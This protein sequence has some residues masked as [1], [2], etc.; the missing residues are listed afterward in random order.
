MKGRYFRLEKQKKRTITTTEIRIF[1]DKKTFALPLLF[2]CSSA[3]PPLFL[4]T[5]LGEAL[6][7]NGIFTDFAPTLHRLWYGGRAELRRN[8]SEGK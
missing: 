5:K 4:R 7:P 3:I 2:P 6:I 1:H 8:Y